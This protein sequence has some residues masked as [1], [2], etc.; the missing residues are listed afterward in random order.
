[1]GDVVNFPDKDMQ[2]IYRT[3]EILCDFSDKILK[4]ISYENDPEKLDHLHSIYNSIPI[5]LYII[6]SALGLKHAEVKKDVQ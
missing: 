5:A 4:M 2:E 1:M 6:D 3:K